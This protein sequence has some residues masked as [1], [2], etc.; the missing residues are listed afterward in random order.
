ML[1]RYR[2]YGLA[3]P[4][5]WRQHVLNVAQCWPFDFRCVR[6]RSSVPPVLRPVNH[7]RAYICGIS[8]IGPAS[9]PPIKAAMV[10]RESI[11]DG[12]DLSRGFHRLFSEDPVDGGAGEC[13]GC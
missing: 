13:R 3:F 11:H 12:L 4:S 7:R 10:G 9:A 2:I 6:S 8:A 1:C 5:R